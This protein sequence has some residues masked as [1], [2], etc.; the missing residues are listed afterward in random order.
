MKHSPSHAGAQWCLEYFSR[1]PLRGQRRTDHRAMTN[2]LPV[3]PHARRQG[4]P[5]TGAQMT[6]K[7]PLRQPPCTAQR[8]CFATATARLTVCTR[9]TTRLAGGTC[10]HEF[11]CLG[12]HARRRLAAAG[13]DLLLP[14]LD[15]CHYLGGVPG[16]G[17]RPWPGWPRAAATRPAPGQRLDG[18]PDRGRCVV[19][20]VRQRPQAAPAAEQ[21]QLAGGLLPG[22]ARDAGLHRGGQPGAAL[23]PA[24]GLGS[25]G[26]DWRHP[27]PDRPGAGR[28]YRSTT[29]RT[30]TG[31]ASACRAKRGSTMASPFR[32]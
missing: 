15:P 24:T 25:I 2:R 32:S 17:R 12:G 1:I 3:S 26:A 5:E 8:R 23:R 21:P 28:W 14:A 19:F 9:V 30:T 31:C 29:R 4:A 16:A 6:I 22:R 13:A 20:P 11:H 7:M 10:A 27:G 18:A